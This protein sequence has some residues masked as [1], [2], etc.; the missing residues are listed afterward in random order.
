M[1]KRTDIAEMTGGRYFRATDNNSLKEIYSEINDLE[2]T[3]L[4]SVTFNTKNEEFWKFSFNYLFLYV[5]SFVLK[6]SYFKKIS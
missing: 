3:K 4:D 1:K 5:L 6:I 2:T